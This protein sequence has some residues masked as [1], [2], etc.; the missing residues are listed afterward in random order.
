MIIKKMLLAF[1]SLALVSHGAM[2]STKSLSKALKGFLTSASETDSPYQAYA[3][4]DLRVGS[5]MPV[6]RITQES[7]QQ[8]MESQKEQDL[9]LPAKM[10][11][12]PVIDGDQVVLF[13]KLVQVGK[14]DW[15][16]VGMGF[17]ELAREVMAVSEVWPLEKQDWILVEN[18]ISREFL[19]SVLDQP[20]ANLN[21]FQF[22]KAEVLEE[23]S[24]ASS[25][26][27]EL[28]DTKLVVT[29]ILETVGIHHEK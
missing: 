24:S 6:W 4:K 11:L 27:A 5:P 26:Y 17:S 7:A 10:V 19:F 16:T 23:G 20:E 14:K 28:I 3:E 21:H 8:Y 15:E 12:V 25:K 13:L 18:E 1:L 22:T 29:Q 9:F 2:P